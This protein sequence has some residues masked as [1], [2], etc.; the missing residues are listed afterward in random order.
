MPLPKPFYP[1]KTIKEKIRSADIKINGNALQ[2]AFSDFGW[3][4]N[5]IAVSL[6]KLNDKYH[7]ID[8]AKNHF[9]K[10]DPHLS[11]PFT[12]LDFYKAFKLYLGEDVYTHLYLK[13]DNGKI[14]VSSFKRK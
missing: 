9:Y 11:L 4:A 7:P 3:D 1:L 8:P 12:M 13:H 5:D 6:K 2:S 10:T 14:V